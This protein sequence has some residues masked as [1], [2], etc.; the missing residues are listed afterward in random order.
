MVPI[1]LNLIE[2]GLKPEHACSPVGLLT[3]LNDYWLFMWFT[4]DKKVA[5]MCLTS[6]ANAFKVMKEVL[7]ERN[8]PTDDEAFPMQFPFLQLPNPLKR[9]RL[10][11]NASGCNDAAYDM[12]ERYELMSD[13]LSPE[14]L[15]QQR[16]DYALNLVRQMPVYSAMY[17]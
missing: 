10:L 3:N 9:R 5:R 15:Q 8:L 2:P 16:I 1:S 7:E 4:E 14:F 17:S 12:L 13:E 11:L 6:P